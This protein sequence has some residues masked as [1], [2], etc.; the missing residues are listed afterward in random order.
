[1][2]DVDMIRS[3]MAVI[4]AGNLTT[5]S[6]MIHITQPALSRRIRLLEDMIGKSLF[7]RKKSGMELSADGNEFLVI[8]KELNK[9]IDQVDNWIKNKKGHL[10]GFVR[11]SSISGIITSILPG[12]LR[13]FTQR[14]TDIKFSIV[15]NVSATIEE[16]VLNGAFNLGIISGR[17]TKQSLSIRALFLHNDLVMA[18]APEFLKKFKKEVTARDIPSDDLLWYANVRSRGARNI[19]KK[20][21]AA[22]FDS[23]GNIQ[24]TDMET[25]KIYA[26]KGLG[27]AIVSKLMI[28]DDVRDGLLDVIPGFSIKVPIYLIS[29]N[30]KYES[31][32]LTKIKEELFDY[33]HKIDSE[34]TDKWKSLTG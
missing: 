11:I 7:L 12:F 33:C 32:L 15:E 24:L 27:V 10:G 34:F 23:I 2:L 14:Y 22:Y 16:G 21:G 5:A 26:F 19:A 29:R 18:A 8:C 6:K 3:F 28:L 20:L 13:S 25:C 1:M 17:C 9:S 30:E 4:K 31:P